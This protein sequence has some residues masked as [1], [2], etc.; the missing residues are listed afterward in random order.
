MPARTIPQ[1][2]RFFLATEGEGEQSFVKWL[3]QLADSEGLHIHLDCKL[4]SGGGLEDMLTRAIVHRKR[5]LKRAF[6]DS[7]LIVDG[8]R[9]ESGDCSID[10][11]RRQADRSNIR[12]CVQQPNQEG[13]LLRML[14]S[15]E[16]LKPDKESAIRLLRAEWP[17]YEKPVDAYTLSRRFSIDDLRR[18]AS[19]DPDLQHFLRL[20][21]LL[22]R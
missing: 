12:V 14:P 17:D 8:D 9:A 19:V 7:F 5:G 16:R 18:V 20:I 1:R 15:K 10:E 21:G 2:T 4:L 22:N 13:L 11:L 3:Q 6:K